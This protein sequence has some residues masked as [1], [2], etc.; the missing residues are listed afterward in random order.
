MKSC[1]VS[2]SERIGGEARSESSEGLSWA[3]S[4][5]AGGREAR[6]FEMG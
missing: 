2:G 5:M 4:K 6:G 1:G 3:R